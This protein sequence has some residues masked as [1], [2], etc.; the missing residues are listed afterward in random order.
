MISF[1]GDLDPFTFAS[2]LIPNISIVLTPV[3]NAG[4]DATSVRATLTK[5]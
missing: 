1:P 4:M 2:L 3:L 5:I